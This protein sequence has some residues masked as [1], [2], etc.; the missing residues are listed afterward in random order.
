[1]TH[2]L[3]RHWDQPDQNSIILDDTHAL[4]SQRAFEALHEYSAST[5][6]GVYPGKMW[7]R[8]DGAFDRRCKPQDR[9]WLLCWYGIVPD[10]PNVCSNNFREI[11][12]A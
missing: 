12:V 3:S 1:M 7:K 5:P 9:R 11:L 6:S 4:M 2:E 10:N 8:H